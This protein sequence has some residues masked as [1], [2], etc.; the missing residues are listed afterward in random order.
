MSR[1]KIFAI[2]TAISV[3]ACLYAC[4]SDDDTNPG[5]AG[6]S[7][8]AG[9]GGNGS[10]GKGG[11]GGSGKGGNG[12]SGNEAGESSAGEGGTD[13]AGGAGGDTGA[14]GDGNGAGGD[15]G[16]AGGGGT[17]QTLAE[18]CATSCDPSH[19]VAT[20]TS[21]LNECVAQC[22]A[23]PGQVQQSV[24]ADPPLISPADAATLNSEYLALVR[25]M[26]T[27]LTATSQ[28]ICADPGTM[29]SKTSPA[30]STVCEDELC[31]WTCDDGTIGT[32]GAD[33][34]MFAR[35]GC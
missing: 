33:A 29:V 2:I 1:N 35:C 8:H 26:A 17:E 30:A 14:A 25:C 15:G 24:D 19:T 7:G 23:Y 6:S 4:G 16:A 31:K 32:F 21:T 34:N 27:H 18:A 9:K 22:T 10:A 28:Y 12:G 5:G 11:N 20:C 13:N 3:S